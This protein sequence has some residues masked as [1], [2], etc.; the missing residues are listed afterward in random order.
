[1]AKTLP[2][3]RS[4]PKLSWRGKSID[5]RQYYMEHDMFVLHPDLVRCLQEIKRR[6]VRAIRSGK[7]LAL[8]I[9]SASGGGKSHF[10]KLL[11]KLWPDEEHKTG[12]YVHLVSFSVPPVPSAASM[13]KALLES[14]GDPG[15][16]R[17]DAF[18]AMKR[19]LGFVADTDTWVVAIDNV[20]DIPERRG[21]KGMLQVGNWIR[22]FIEKSKRLVVLLGTPAAEEIVLANPQLRRRNPGKAWMRYFDGSTEKGLARLMRFLFETDKLLPLAEWSDLKQF[23]HKIYFASYGIPD[24]IFQ[25]LAEAVDIAVAAGRERIEEA[26]L[27]QA[28]ERIFLDA[29]NGLNPFSAH[30]PQR[31]L[32]REGEPFNEWYGASNPELGNRRTGAPSAS[33][34]KKPDGRPPDD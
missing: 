22:D 14:M 3:L 25:I 17:G 12:T 10:L 19:A 33:T 13:P 18:E 27:E 15:W 20:H 9:L 24:Y 6:M 30:G 2:K 16:N 32:D 31:V 5:V 4:P 7:G 28:F 29:G 1:M 34:R 8:F 11:K 23:A 21:R 26:D